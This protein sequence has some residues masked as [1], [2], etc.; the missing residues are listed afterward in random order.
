MDEP[1]EQ[2]GLGGSTLGNRGWQVF[3][4]WGWESFG[5]HMKVLMWYWHFRIIKNIRPTIENVQGERWKVA[6]RSHGMR[7]V[8]SRR[9]TW[10]FVTVFPLFDFAPV[11]VL[12]WILAHPYRYLSSCGHRP[13]VHT[14]CLS[15]LE[16]MPELEQLI[17]NLGFM[18]CSHKPLNFWD[19]GKSLKGFYNKSP[20]PRKLFRQNVNFEII[21]TFNLFPLLPW[22]M[23]DK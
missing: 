3:E 22:R 23:N 19:V 14:L 4:G 20:L 1:S 10:E 2:V 15:E 12:I 5:S 13:V 9:D 7:K 6:Q 18:L 8:Q 21:S 17:W 11:F 16:K